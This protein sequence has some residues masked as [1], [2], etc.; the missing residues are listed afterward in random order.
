MFDG[1]GPH[2]HEISEMARRFLQKNIETFLPINVD[3]LKYSSLKKA[4]K[5]TTKHI[6][7]SS[8]KISLSGITNAIL[9]K[10]S[11]LMCANV[12]DSRA[13]LGKRVNR[14]WEALALS[15]DNKPSL[16]DERFVSSMQMVVSGQCTTVITD[17]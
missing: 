11:V 16:L 2:G 12:G 13:V 10:G 17:R 3:F 15:R 6:E 5:L 1:H 14:R 8:I 4:I 7:E 9:I